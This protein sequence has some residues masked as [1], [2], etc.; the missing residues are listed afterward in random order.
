MKRRT[1]AIVVA[2]LVGYSAMMEK[3][4]VVAA[5]RVAAV[6]QLIGEKARE[7]D[8]RVFNTAGDAALMEFPSA[9]ESIRCASEVRTSLALGNTHDGEPMRMRF[10]LHLADVIVQGDDLIGDGVNLAARIQQTAE[11]NDILV[12]GNLFDHVRRNSPYRFE[13]LGERQF[14]NIGEPIPV[15]RVSGEMSN[16]RMRIAPTREPVTHDR[17]PSS[18][19][20]LP[21]RV[22]SSEDDQRYLAD[23]LTDELIVELGRFRRLFVVSRSASFGIAEKGASALEAGL[24]LGVSHVLEGQV[25]KLGKL[26]RI[27]LTLTETETGAVVWSDKLQRPF[28]ELLDVLDEVTSRVAATVCGRVFE[29]S[30][31]AARRKAPENMSALECLYRGLDHHRMGA[32]SEEHTREAVRWFDR[33]IELDPGFGPAYAWRVCS[34]SNLPTFNLEKGRQDIRLAMQLDPMDPESQRIMATIDL[35]DENHEQALARITRAIELN[36]SDAFLKARAATFLCFMGDR[37][38]AMRSLQEAESLD[39][40]LPVWCVEQRGVVHYAHDD[41][42][43]AL[44]TLEGLQFPTIRARLYAA[45]SLVA[46]DRL[47]EARRR[48]QEATLS[49]QGLSVQGCLFQERYK[50]ASQR[51]LLAERLQ[52]AGLPMKP[53]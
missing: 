7:F 37:A 35:W 30:L 15:Y 24:A 47:P 6:Q 18:V 5:Q 29:G 21:L 44:M 11:P 27:S 9:V 8:G 10:G 3:S 45:A 40:M 36:P 53:A 1:A 39:P 49:L 51:Q 32:V 33:A 34:S 19:A 26:V 4:E 14:K 16:H 28:D 20:V 31:V 42:P 13:S 23:A 41:Y 50:D 48:V 12:S 25:R 43:K 46:M 38:G 17:R 2:D 52:Q 22:S